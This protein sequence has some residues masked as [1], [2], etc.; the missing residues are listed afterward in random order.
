MV[1]VLTFA[2]GEGAQIEQK[3]AEWVKPNAAQIRPVKARRVQQPLE[4]N[5]VKAVHGKRMAA[6]ANVTAKKLA[7]R[8]TKMDTAAANT[9]N[10]ASANDNAPHSIKLIKSIAWP[11]RST[12]HSVRARTRL[13]GTSFP[14]RKTAP[15]PVRKAVLQEI[16]YSPQGVSIHV[17]ERSLGDVLRQVEGE[18]NIAFDIRDAA[19]A[20]IKISARIMASDWPKATLKLLDDFSRIDIWDEDRL[21][22]VVLLGR[23]NYP[24]K[25]IRKTPR[26]VNSVKRIF[27]GK[28]YKRFLS[29]K[30]LRYLIRTP[31]NKPLPASLIQDWEYRTFLKP[32]GIKTLED[33]KNM[34]NT[35]TV[36]L[37]VRRQLRELEEQKRPKA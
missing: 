34:N 32:F 35:Q 9:K 12:G 30:K 10:A 16:S 15:L 26:K 1:F 22:R 28:R 17:K 29:E 14:V 18:A 24:T 31:I 8:G 33:L 36:R 3:P 25:Y 23:G 5:S 4:R 19:L 21:S 6:R 7:N 27:S 2:G 13:K 11:T 20:D 37:E